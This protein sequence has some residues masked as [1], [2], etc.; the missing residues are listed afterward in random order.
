MLL[1]VF[2]ATFKVDVS[3]VTV[4]IDAVAFDTEASGDASRSREL[5]SLDTATLDTFV[6]VKIEARTS[7]LVSS[8]AIF[9]RVS[10]GEG[11][12]KVVDAGDVANDELFAE[13]GWPVMSLEFSVCLRQ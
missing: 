4:S 6:L 8:S 10:S 12:D 3:F 7:S 5:L 9:R 11:V 13:P 2:A 1:P